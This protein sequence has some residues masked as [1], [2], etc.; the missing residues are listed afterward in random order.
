[1]ANDP[2]FARKVKAQQELE[3][4]NKPKKVKPAPAA[5]NEAERGIEAMRF[6]R[7][8]ELLLQTPKP[9]AYPKAQR[10]AWNTRQLKSGDVL[11]DGD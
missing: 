11:Y 10:E 9:Q 1:M 5:Y 2:A 8:A 6:E 7:I 4:A 3:R